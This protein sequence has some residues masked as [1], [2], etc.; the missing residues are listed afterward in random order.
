MGP[1]P[2]DLHNV[3][4]FYNLINQSVLNIDST[5][6]GARQIAYELFEGRRGLVRVFPQDIKQSLGFLSQPC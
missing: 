1:H 6:A 4:F 2:K 3:G 5:R